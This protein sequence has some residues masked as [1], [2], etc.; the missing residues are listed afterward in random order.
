MYNVSEGNPIVN[1]DVWNPQQRV[2]LTTDTNLPSEIEANVYARNAV[3]E[4][5][6]SA[7]P[8]EHK[9]VVYSLPKNTTLEPQQKLESIIDIEILQ[10]GF[11]FSCQG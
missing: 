1:V 4:M 11:L 3:A 6:V 7:K 8:T 10:V 2:G 5:M 9:P